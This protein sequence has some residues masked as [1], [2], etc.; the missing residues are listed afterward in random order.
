MP[1]DALV[2]A[3]REMMFPSDASE[4]LLGRMARVAAATSDA[5]IEATEKPWTSQF[6]ANV[7]VNRPVVIGVRHLH[8][9]VQPPPEIVIQDEAVFYSRMSRALGEAMSSAFDPTIMRD[10]VG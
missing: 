6:V 9:H 10:R 2:L 1:R 4:A 5:F 8:V 7:F 3:K